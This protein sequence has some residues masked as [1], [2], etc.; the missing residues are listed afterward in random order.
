[1]TP[2]QLPSVT[3]CLL[4]LEA[5]AFSLRP[6]ETSTELNI[7]GRRVAGEHCGPPQEIG[8]TMT[9]DGD[10]EQGGDGAETGRNHAG[11]AHYQSF[12]AAIFHGLYGLLTAVGS[13]G[14]G[15]VA[16]VG[17]PGLFAR[18]TCGILAPFGVAYGWHCLHKARNLWMGVRPQENPSPFLRPFIREE[19]TW[20]WDVGDQRI[21]VEKENSR[22]KMR[23]RDLERVTIVT[24]SDGPASE[25]LFFV[26]ESSEAELVV[27]HLIAEDEGLV[28]RLLQLPEFDVETFVVAAGSTSE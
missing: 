27:P 19:H 20:D 16:V 26:L 28:S 8:T 6:G 9:I 17:G 21:E 15:A 5:I 23:Y 12:G 13:L 2:K 7:Q 4:L 18:L 24:T 1:M 14:A 22:V 10:D 25:D 3:R 11:D